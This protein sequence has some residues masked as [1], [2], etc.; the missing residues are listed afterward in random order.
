MSQ[1]G[2]DFSTRWF[3][4]DTIR[5]IPPDL[6]NR[7]SPITQWLVLTIFV[8]FLAQGIAAAIF[9]DSIIGVTS[10]FFLEYPLS[11][12]LLSFFLHKGIIHFLAN[13][14]LIGIT[15]RVVEQYFSTRAYFRFI[16][17]AAVF[18]GIGGFLFQALFTPNPVA[19]YGAS[20]FGYALAT[21]SLYLPFKG[22]LSSWR[23]M[24]PE[25]LWSN[26]TPAERFV[27]L[28]GVSAIIKITYDLATGPYFTVDWT[29]G[30]HLIGGL[31]GLIVGWIYPPT[32][33]E[34]AMETD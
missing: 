12:W 34:R 3:V 27:F 16:A 28:L 19:A 8:V 2:Q 22:N 13:I 20:G 25:N 31:V 17:V 18:S 33:S 1:S 14:A 32:L 24:K 6:S 30:A 23:S 21:Y 5:N 7:D 29:N 9:Q 15:G 11:A 10:F 4:T 26:T